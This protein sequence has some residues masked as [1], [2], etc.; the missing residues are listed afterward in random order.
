MLLLGILID[1]APFINFKHHY[2]SD[3][4]LSFRMI[5]FKFRH[6]GACPHSCIPNVNFGSSHEKN[7]VLQF[8]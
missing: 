4:F 5:E 2:T 6:L 7:T 1:S 3:I 8:H